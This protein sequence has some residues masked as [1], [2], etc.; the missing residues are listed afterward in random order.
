MADMIIALANVQNKAIPQGVVFRTDELIVVEELKK[1]GIYATPGAVTEYQWVDCV[2]WGCVVVECRTSNWRFR[3]KGFGWRVNPTRHNRGI[4]GDVVVLVC[5]WPR[6]KRTFHV[7][8]V[9]C[10]VFY[11]NGKLKQG[12]KWTPRSRGSTYGIAHDIASLTDE[13]MDEA[14]DAWWIIEEKRKLIS[15]K[16]TAG[17]YSRT[18]NFHVPKPQ[19][20][21]RP[22]SEIVQLDMFGE[23]E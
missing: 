10:P 5:N 18:G 1:N 13:L 6:A 16:L 20:P 21:E 2:A 15:E 12:I 11:H 8:G 9:E 3:R 17:E 23:I 7:F 4:Q 19:M 22:K 14:Q